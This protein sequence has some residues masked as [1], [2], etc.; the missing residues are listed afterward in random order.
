MLFLVALAHA[1]CPAPYTPAQLAEDLRAVQRSLREMDDMTFDDAGRRLDAGLP[2]LDKTLS[3]Q[4]YAAVYRYLGAWYWIIPGN[5]TTARAWFRTSLELEPDFEW[6]VEELDAASPMRRDWDTERAVA[7]AEP[8][9]VQGKVLAGEVLLDGR[10]LTA[11]SA[12]PGRPHIV[13]LVG[14]GSVQTWKIEGAA[15]PE[16][17]VVDPTATVAVEEPKKGKKGEVAATSTTT[18]ATSGYDVVQIER[19][20]PPAKTPLLIAGVVG[21]AAAGGVYGLAWMSHG[22]F[23]ESTTTADV[24]SLQARTNALVLA[25]GGTLLL[26]IGI[27]GWGALLDGGGVVGFTTPF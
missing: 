6:D 22:Q 18:P 23:E 17:L 24:E 11:P 2:C 27:G 9:T 25:S 4:A 8:V 21:M 12:T 20:R 16:S 14:V 15:F 3:P 10:R 13:Q 19:Q 26:G 5:T 1:A 7:L